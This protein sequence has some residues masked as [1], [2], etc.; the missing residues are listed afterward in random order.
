MALEVRSFITAL[1]K[2]AM[3]TWRLLAKLH[4]QSAQLFLQ[5]PVTTT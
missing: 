2:P 3:V 1:P 5:P 4:V